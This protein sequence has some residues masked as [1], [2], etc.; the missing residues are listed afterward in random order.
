MGNKD[1]RRRE[2]KKLKKDTKKVVPLSPISTAS[3]VEVTTKGKAAK[4]SKE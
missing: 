1:V 4:E 3:P 2:Q